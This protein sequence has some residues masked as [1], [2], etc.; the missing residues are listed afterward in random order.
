MTDN[1]TPQPSSEMVNGCESKPAESGVEASS[2][3]IASASPF[4]IQ[5]P[6][7]SVAEDAKVVTT[8]VE[9][10]NKVFREAETGIFH[11]GY[12]RT[13]KA[14]IA[15]LIRAGLLGIATVP[16]GDIQAQQDPESTSTHKDVSMKVIGCVYVT[17]LSAKRGN[18]GMLALDAEHH[19]GGLGR[20]MVQFAENHCQK[21]GCTIMQL[22]LLVPT[23]FEHAF[24]TRME[25]WYQRMGYQ[26]IKLGS[27]DKEY[28]H[29][30]PHLTGPMDYKYFEKKLI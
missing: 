25:A 16:A 21:Q 11:P 2:A 19:G 24:K 13:S 29:L 4:T 15:N 8:I 20:A 10:V 1:A 6:D 28:P 7:V 26:V 9:I 12:E 22:E 17:Q 14:E 5:F 30:A 18:F 3:R 27:F 23:T